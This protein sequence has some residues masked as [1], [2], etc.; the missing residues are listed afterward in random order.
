MR[1]CSSR[2]DTPLADD[3]RV[4]L[5]VRASPSQFARQ[6]ESDIYQRQAKAQRAKDLR[7]EKRRLGEEEAL[8]RRADRSGVEANGRLTMKAGGVNRNY[9]AGAS[10]SFVIE[11]E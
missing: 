10:V 3:S 7:M 8:V 5:L 6:N 1:T 4:L 11:S 9:L 2:R